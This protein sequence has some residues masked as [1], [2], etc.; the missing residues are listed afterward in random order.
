V[1]HYS[2]MFK[3][4]VVAVVNVY[5]YANDGDVCC[6]DNNDDDVAVMADVEATAARHWQTAR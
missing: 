6:D 3:D 4:A 2:A 5:V 1:Y